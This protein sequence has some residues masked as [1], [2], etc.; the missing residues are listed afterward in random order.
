MLKSIK[1][2]WQTTITTITPKL[3]SNKNIPWHDLR[4]FPHVLSLKTVC[5]KH[6]YCSQSD[7]VLTTWNSE[8]IPFK[9]HTQFRN[10]SL[11][12]QPKAH[13]RRTSTAGLL[14]TASAWLRAGCWAVWACCCSAGSPAEPSCWTAPQSAPERPLQIDPALSQ[15]WPCKTAFQEFSENK[16]KRKRFSDKTFWNFKVILRREIFKSLD[17]EEI[18]PHFKC[19]RCEENFKRCEE[20]II[21]AESTLKKFFITRKAVGSRNPTIIGKIFLKFWHSWMWLS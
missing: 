16:K 9:N 15:L 14:S 1:S 3:L 7:L 5:L 21:N 17:L 6:G 10:S 11:T 12:F 8:Q 2:N 18:V 4:P 19:K 13:A 20:S